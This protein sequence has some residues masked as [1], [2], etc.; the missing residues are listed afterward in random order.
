MVVKYV[1]CLVGLAVASRPSILFSNKS[2]YESSTQLAEA[3]RS[4]CRQANIVAPLVTYFFVIFLIVG[5]PCVYVVSRVRDRLSGYDARVGPRASSLASFGGR[6]DTPK[7]LLLTCAVSLALSSMNLTIGLPNMHQI[8]QKFNGSI[9]F[10]GLVLGVY[11]FGAILGLP[12]F[13]WFVKDSFRGGFVAQ[14]VL[15]VIGNF[16]WL[17]VLVQKSDL[18][19]L[20]VG[21]L[22]CGLEGGSE[23]VCHYSLRTC[24]SSSF[25]SKA[26]TVAHVM[27]DLGACFGF[28]LSS[29]SRQYPATD[30]VDKDALPTVDLLVVCLVFLV[31][32]LLIFPSQ[33]GLLSTKGVQHSH[34][35]E[36]TPIEPSGS[37]KDKHVLADIELRVA[38]L[39]IMTALSTNLLRATQRTSWE[40]FAGLLLSDVYHLG[41][42]TSGYVICICALA[43]LVSGILIFFGSSTSHF[44]LARKIAICQAVGIVLMVRFGNPGPV[45]FV[46]FLLGSGMFYGSNAMHMV[47]V[48]AAVTDFML[49]KHPVL[50]DV[51]FHALIICAKYVGVFFGPI[52]SR[53]FQGRCMH[54]NMG[55]ALFG[56]TFFFQVFVVEVCL[57][58]LRNCKDALQPV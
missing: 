15:L 25:L 44:A 41:S 29:F 33:Q 39:A 58:A 43:V 42:I 1:A 34:E 18:R 14:G 36:V 23:M 21:R 11:G 47:P 7:L 16:A 32:M 31:L 57:R 53:M 52:T 56:L 54:Q 28:A 37:T 10:S 51:N 27:S 30:A 13:V 19:S 24:T 9:A 50:N 38:W 35:V 49:Q 12:L 26:F 8:V 2:H 3:P 40:S 48:N 6:G 20:V 5:A 4:E 55:V 22:L 45:S 17:S 46:M